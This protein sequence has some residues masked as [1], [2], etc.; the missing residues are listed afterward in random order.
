MVKITGELLTSVHNQTLSLVSYLNVW[1][2]R[3]V[4]HKSFGIFTV[5]LGLKS[6]PL[7]AVTASMLLS[8][9]RRK[10]AA[11]DERD[12]VRIVLQGGHYRNTDRYF[13][14]TAQVH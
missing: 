2:L 8:H 9:R 13:A 12:K 4:E 3:H 5:S 10:A 6:H 11:S 14:T 1:E 7:F